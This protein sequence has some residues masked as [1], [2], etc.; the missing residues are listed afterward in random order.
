MFTPEDL[1]VFAVIA[2]QA[3]L[4]IDRVRSRNEIAQQ[5]VESMRD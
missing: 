5:T 2:M 1:N 4:A 3:G